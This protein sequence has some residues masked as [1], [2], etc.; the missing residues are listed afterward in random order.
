MKHFDS[1][2]YRRSQIALRKAAEKW[3]RNLSVEP[4]DSSDSTS[5][6]LDNALQTTA[7]RYV[8]ARLE[9]MGILGDVIGAMKS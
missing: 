4:I 3:G 1:K 9:E 5:K 6:R 2:K 7:I 8:A